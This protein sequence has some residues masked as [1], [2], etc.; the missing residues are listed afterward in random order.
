MESLTL[1]WTVGRAK[2]RDELRPSCRAA[3]ISPCVSKSLALLNS[4]DAAVHHEAIHAAMKLNAVKPIHK[5]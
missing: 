2:T 4:N 1:S 3:E 5:L